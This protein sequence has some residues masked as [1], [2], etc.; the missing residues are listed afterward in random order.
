MVGLKVMSP[1]FIENGEIF[2]LK[3]NSGW[4]TVDAPLMIMRLDNISADNGEKFK[5]KVIATYQDYQKSA[6]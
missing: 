3:S 2:V 4:F 1:I 5:E 6:I